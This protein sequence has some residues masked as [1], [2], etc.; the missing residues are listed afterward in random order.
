MVAMAAIVAQNGATGQSLVEQ[1]TTGN[2]NPFIGGY[3][4]QD[5]PTWG[6]W[7]S[8]G[9]WSSMVIWGYDL[10]CLAIPQHKAMKSYEP[11]QSHGG[12]GPHGAPCQLGGAAVGASATRPG[13][14]EASSRIDQE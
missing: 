7:G 13:W 5:W 1:F 9:W 2:L 14:G 11:S 4:K 10:E 6:S 3:A 8:W 12:D